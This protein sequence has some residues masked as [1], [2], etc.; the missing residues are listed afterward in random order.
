[1]RFVP[2]N[3]LKEGMIS[4]R[5]IVGRQ[6]E[7]LVNSGAVIYD[8]YAKRIRELGYSGIYIEDKLSEDIE[9]VEIINQDLRFKTVKAVKNTFAMME[10]GKIATERQMKELSSL[11]DGIVDEALSNKGLMINMMDLKIFD[12]YTFYHSVNATVLSVVLGISLNMNRDQLYKLA[13]SAMLHDIGKVFIPKEILNKPGKLNENEFEIMKSHS[14]RGYQYL[15]EHCDIPVLS[16]IGILHHHEKYDGTGY[17]SNTKGEQISLFGRI[18]AVADIYD[19]LTSDR[20]YRKA[21]MP[22]EAAEYVMGAGGTVIDPN[23]AKMFMQNIA[24]Y[25]IGVCVL[26]SNNYQG[27]VVENYRDCCTRPKIKVI[28]QDNR[29]VTPYIMDLKNDAATRGITIIGV[30]S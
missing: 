24:P 29:E 20:P 17:P 13:V 14:F 8:S 22:S 10:S 27:L 7:L 25:P 12:D 30:V 4:A 19:A 9:V 15:K 1:M 16:Y 28:R 2:V 3:C 21:M 6:G 5:Q 26:L 11:I 18:I 23:L